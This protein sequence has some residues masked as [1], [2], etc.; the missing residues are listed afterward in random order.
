MKFNYNRWIRFNCQDFIFIT[1]L[2]QTVSLQRDSSFFVFFQVMFTCVHTCVCMCG[3]G[4]VCN[5]GCVGKWR[6]WS[7]LKMMWVVFVFVLWK[8]LVEMFRTVLMVHLNSYFVLESNVIY[9]VWIYLM[10]IPPPQRV[11]FSQNIYL[12]AILALIFMKL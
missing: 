2:I 1:S 10:A 5:C 7:N 12:A 9:E 11:V 3:W 4:E 8:S 6:G